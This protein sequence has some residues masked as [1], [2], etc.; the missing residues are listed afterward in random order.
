MKVRRLFDILDYYLENKPNQ[1]VALAGKID[2]EWRKY[3]I[4]EYIAIA[5]NL[6]FAMI[7]LGVQPGDKVAIISTNRPE[8]NMLDMAIMQIGAI[9]VPVYPTISES[10]YQYICRQPT[11]SPRLL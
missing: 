11:H 2:K 8:W 7:K 3:S 10:D 1:E 4:Q 5:N 9:T 6:S